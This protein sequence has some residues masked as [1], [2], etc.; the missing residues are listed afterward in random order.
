MAPGLWSE[1]QLRGDGYIL[2]SMF[3]VT[4]LTYYRDGD[5]IIGER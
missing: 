3:A 4:P 5:K 2:R 1:P